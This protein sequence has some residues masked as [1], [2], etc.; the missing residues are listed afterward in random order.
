MENG[1]QKEGQI[2]GHAHKLQLNQVIF[3]GEKYEKE[4]DVKFIKINRTHIN[5]LCPYASDSLAILSKRVS[6][7]A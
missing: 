1:C 7:L 3:P 2:V 6:H 4:D 5:D